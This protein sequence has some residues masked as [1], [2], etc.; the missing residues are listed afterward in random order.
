[1]KRREPQ[2]IGDIIDQVVAQAGLTETMAAQRACYLWPE[3][4]GPGINRYTSR[5]YV[6]GSVLHVYI[7]S[8][9]LRNELSFMRSKIVESLNAIVGSGV[10]TDL[11]IH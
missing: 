10:I 6:D 9:P 4:V 7:T 2:L 3:I 8:A 11:I 5:R 1:M